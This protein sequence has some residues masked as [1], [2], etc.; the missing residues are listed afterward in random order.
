MPLTSPLM[1]YET[2]DRSNDASLM[3]DVSPSESTWVSDG[4]L[5]LIVNN[6]SVVLA[7]VSLA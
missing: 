2:H 6:C 1:T 4:L 7:K 5:P 3:N